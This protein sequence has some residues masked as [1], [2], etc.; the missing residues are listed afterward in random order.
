[1]KTVALI[2]PE[3]RTPQAGGGG[4]AALADFV[5]HALNDPSVSAWERLRV[6]FVVPRMFNAAPEHWSPRRPGSWWR[7]P[8]ASRR[9]GQREIWDV[10]A[11]LPEFERN[12]YRPRKVL[13]SLLNDCDAAIVIAGTPAIGSVMSGTRVPW[14]LEV[15]SLVEEERAARLASTSGVRG[16]LLRAATASTRRAD[17]AALQL[18]DAIATLNDSLAEKLR[19]LTSRP[20]RLLT[21]GVDTTAFRPAPTRAHAGP[22]IMVSRLNDHRK[23]LPTLLRAYHHARTEHGVVNPLVLAGRHRPGP[24]EL[25]LIDDLELTRVV[26]VISSPSDDELASLLRKASCFALASREEGLGVV[27]LEAMA[28]G[29]PIVTTATRGARF[30]VP[31]DV[32]DVLPFGSSLVHDFATALARMTADRSR[33]DRMGA[34]ARQHAMREFDR[35]VA[36][37]RWRALAWELVDKG[38]RK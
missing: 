21:P 29:L 35:D 34:A 19:S 14:A 16:V 6:R 8:I 22:I 33:A 31:A 12:R 30:A 37:A 18:P 13:S 23:D 26:Q 5:D 25:R 15:A 4:L 32:G 9:P 17:R 24:H 36:A 20:V 7:G 2:V 27:F 3:Y 10:G 1:M 28:S 11:W 38:P